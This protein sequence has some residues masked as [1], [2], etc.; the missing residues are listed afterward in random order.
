MV[1]LKNVALKEALF[2]QTQQVQ[3]LDLFDL[4]HYNGVSIG[5]LCILSLLSVIKCALTNLN[6]MEKPKTFV[7]LPQFSSKQ[8]DNI[9]HPAGGTRTSCN[10]T[11]LLKKKQ[12]K[13]HDFNGC[14]LFC[15][16]H[17]DTKE[18]RTGCCLQLLNISFSLFLSF[19]RLSLSSSLC[20]LLPTHFL[21]RAHTHIQT[22]R[23]TTP[24]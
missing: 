13:Q 15:R 12:K 6:E 23:S 16:N 3:L 18:Q 9:S 4:S 17:P 8:R 19:C 20:K 22:Q 7:T 11:S 10:D 1:V 24:F 14:L 5:D 21:S 2:S